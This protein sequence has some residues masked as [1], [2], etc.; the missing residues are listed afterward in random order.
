[1]GKRRGNRGLAIVISLVL[2][3]VL[4]EGVLVATVLIWPGAA[5]RLEGVAGSVDRAWSG[6]E[7]EPGIAARAGDALGGF[8]RGWIRPLW[9][10]QERPGQPAEFAGCASCHEDYAE[11]R[12]FSSVYMNHPLHAEIGVACA[13]CHRVTAHPNPGSPEEAVCAGCHQEVDER[14]GC[15]LCHAPASLPHFAMLGAPK[16][17]PVDCRTCHPRT[18]LPSGR[19][20]RLVEVGTFDGSQPKACASCHPRTACEQCHAQEHPSGWIGSHGNDVGYTGPGACYTCH[21]SAWCADRCHAT[22]QVHGSVPRPLPTA[23][24]R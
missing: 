17:G 15:G 24:E 22:G 12:R 5:T 8:Y 13:D 18:P 19:A 14:Q 16:Q 7:D 9:A 20:E 21:T 2:L 1:M 4:A 3:L 10:S 23:G 11:K 6:T